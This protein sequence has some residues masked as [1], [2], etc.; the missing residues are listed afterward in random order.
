MSD[1]NIAREFLQIVL[2]PV[3]GF[4]IEQHVRLQ[5][6][7]SDIKLVLTQC[8]SELLREQGEKVTASKVSTLTGVHRK[9]VSTILKTGETPKVSGVDVIA[10]ILTAWESDPRFVDGRRSPRGLIYGSEHSE[11]GV[12]VSSVTSDVRASTILSELERRGLVE[13]RSGKVV[14]IEG[15][16]R[17]PQ[18]PVARF[19]NLARN[20]KYLFQAA[21]ENLFSPREP[22]NAHLRTEF[23][24]LSSTQLE[25]LRDWVLKENI[26]FHKRLREKL[27][28]YERDL[29]PD[30]PGDDLPITLSVTS[31]SLTFPSDRN[32]N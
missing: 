2:E 30:A 12:L 23:E 19:R 10:K 11:F 13:K 8:A 26:D 6:I 7:V 25:E 1:N 18:E 14:L 15:Y 4:S 21:Q 22:R 16:N 31:Y 17:L 24:N 32:E 5:D 28:Q 3:I 29:M 27:T 9:D 20:V